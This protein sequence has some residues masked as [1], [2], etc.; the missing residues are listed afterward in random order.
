MLTDEQIERKIARL[1]PVREK[2]DL[3]NELGRRLYFSRIDRAFELFT[4]ALALAT[5]LKH[6]PGIALASQWL[7]SYYGRS[8]HWQQ[9]LPH[10]ERALRLY[11]D[12]RDRQGEGIALRLIGEAYI[13]AADY[14][15]AEQTLRNAL[16]IQ[17]QERDEDSAGYTWS[18][19]GFLYWKLARADDARTAFESAREIFTS[20]G[21][22]RQ[23]AYITNNIAVLE[24]DQGNYARAL[25]MLEQLVPLREQMGDI[26]GLIE[27]Y[28]NIGNQYAMF[29]DYATA[30]EYMLK[31]L[32][33]REELNV[34]RRDYAM[35]NIAYVYSKLGQLDQAQE[36]YTQALAIAESRNDRAEICDYHINIAAVQLKMGRIE[37]AIEH[38]RTALAIAAESNNEIHAA[39]AWTAIAEGHRRTG[40]LPEALEAIEQAIERA[41]RTGR[42]QNL[43]EYL[44]AMAVILMEMGELDQ[45]LSA[46]TESLTLALHSGRT[47]ALDRIYSLLS[48]LH[49]NRGEILEA[50]QASRHRYD[51]Y[52]ATIDVSTSH[53]LQTLT[54]QFDVER[55]RKDAEIS[56][57][58]ARE[59]ELELEMKKK[60]LSIMA[61]HL[62]SKNEF[63]MDLRRKIGEDV[64]RTDTFIR[65][66]AGRIEQ[67]IADD[68][69]W[70]DFERRFTQTNPEFAARLM[71]QSNAKLSPTEL[72]ICTLLRTGLSTKEIANVLVV[73]TRTIDSHRY[74][75]HRKLG[76]G[77]RKLVAYLMGM[78]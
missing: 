55:M 32:K 71:E 17:Q 65:E 54:V 43:E 73:S 21:N 31:G 16:E 12:L 47:G 48:D 1:G 28:G 29:A 35:S 69:E 24:S 77:D 30:L 62:V 34:G 56:R 78:G 64:D 49:E 9:S 61:L 46:A 14:P 20:L 63:L 19:L 22:E 26:S 39:G 45:S 59:I 7:A 52:S 70:G 50:L 33:L 23:S 18:S 75:I 38:A 68:S 44:L 37:S 76:L 10:A 72:K 25:A 40:N 57:L 66:L 41:R 74:N 36:Y 15:L 2:A 67:G 51:A 58:N 8:D 53:K 42:E 27:T 5:E 60:E 4:Q 6:A 3:L 13:T 11:R